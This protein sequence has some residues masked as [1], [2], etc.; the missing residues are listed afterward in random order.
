M[1]QVGDE[2][3]GGVGGGGAP[4]PKMVIQPRSRSLDPPWPRSL[5]MA[6]GNN[7]TSSRFQFSDPTRSPS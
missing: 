5:T 4:G 6:S 7:F 3:G 2:E 1:S